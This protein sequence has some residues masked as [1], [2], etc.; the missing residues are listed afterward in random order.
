MLA[1]DHSAACS[2]VVYGRASHY[3]DYTFHNEVANTVTLCC[4]YCDTMTVVY[5]CVCV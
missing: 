3:E 2:H 1:V 4:C 5:V